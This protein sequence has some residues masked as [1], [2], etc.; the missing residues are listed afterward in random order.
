MDIMLIHIYL[1][2]W[3]QMMLNL[4]SGLTTYGNIIEERG[5]GEGGS[6]KRN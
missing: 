2:I 1:V 5:R 3:K 6:R 4:V